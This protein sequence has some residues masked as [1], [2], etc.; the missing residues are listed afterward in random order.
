MN[1]GAPQ[2]FV[3]VDIADA[4][5]YGLIEQQSLDARTARA[6]SLSEI[7]RAHLQRISA[8]VRE[9]VGEQRAGEIRHASEAAGIGGAPPP[10]AL[11]SEPNR[12]VVF[13]RVRRRAP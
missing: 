9:L 13:A 2:T 11:A 10:A 5:Q 12:G 8:K 1:L 4:A 3:G 7:Q 6:D